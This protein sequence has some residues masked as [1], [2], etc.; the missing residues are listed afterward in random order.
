MA[1]SNKKSAEQGSTSRPH[2]TNASNNTSSFASASHAHSG[3]EREEMVAN[4]QEFVREPVG[5][6][7]G[8]RYHLDFDSLP[9][10]SVTSYL[11]KNGLAPEFGKN[12]LPSLWDEMQRVSDPRLLFSNQAPAGT[13]TSADPQDSSN[14]G[15]APPAK[16]SKKSSK[17]ANA[18]SDKPEQ[19]E[20]SA[21]AKR[22]S[23]TTSMSAAII[24]ESV[25]MAEEEERRREREAGKHTELKTGENQ[26]EED[27][28]EHAD[29]EKDRAVW[30]D[31]QKTEEKMNE[32]TQSKETAPHIEGVNTSEVKGQSLAVVIDTVTVSDLDAAVELR[33]HK[34]KASEL[35]AEE[36]TEDRPPPANADQE[37]TQQPTDAQDNQ[38]Y[39]DNTAG[40]VDSIASPPAE[41]GVDTGVDSAVDAVVNTVGDTAFDS[42]VD[43]QIQ[44]SQAAIVE[45]LAEGTVEEG[46]VPTT[47][48]NAPSTETESVLA[49]AA[50]STETDVPAVQAETDAGE[51]KAD[52]AI[53]STAINVE[54]SAVIT[55]SPEQI[56]IEEVGAEVEA[57]AKTEAPTD[58]ETKI[59]SKAAMD[60]EHTDGDKDVEMEATAEEDAERATAENRPL[61]DAS[62]VV[63][64]DVHDAEK[65]IEE[66]KPTN[67]EPMESVEDEQE[68]DI[69]PE[70]PP[71]LRRSSR[72][73]LPVG[74]SLAR[75]HR[76]TRPS[77]SPTPSRESGDEEDEEEEEPFRPILADLDAAR[78]ILA[79][80]AAK[81]W[82][83]TLAAGGG[84]TIQGPGVNPALAGQ[85]MMGATGG[86]MREGEAISD[87]L[88][89]ARLKG[90][91][92]KLPPRGSYRITLNQKCATNLGSSL[93]IYKD[94]A[95][96]TGF[97]HGS[98]PPPFAP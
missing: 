36:D 25:R 53:S 49:A 40:A 85:V 67:I 87:F 98:Q 1:P 72:K 15:A 14:F 11:Y 42:G 62:A 88:Y 89:A 64:G 94:P 56:T 24:E 61:K 20:K 12:G 96:P 44:D 34:R 83:E 97:P 2:H 21:T 31:T 59:E 65:V 37:K 58:P 71:A 45:A 92:F 38:Q 4:I 57:A 79:Q 77:P 95:M 39:T 28:K 33:G 6:I 55:T 75:T 22:R 91:F 70:S 9:T 51:T 86:M 13:E 50:E 46:E 52:D 68:P 80:R 7:E 29:Q 35:E 32:S 69:P 54:E 93:K 26:A 27:G 10:S 66:S 43:A 3:R 16:K 63:P 18:D 84:H 30:D 74:T 5:E 81:H 8:T 17:A 73:P 82:C 78:H 23:T 19:P 47:E 48:P 41:A 90:E 60:D 76:D